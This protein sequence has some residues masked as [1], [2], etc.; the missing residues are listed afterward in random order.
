MKIIIHDREKYE[1]YQIEWAKY[2]ATKTRDD[3]RKYDDYVD[4]V[5]SQ[6][7]LPPEEWTFKSHPDYCRVTE[8]VT[9][10]QGCGF[11]DR[12]KLEY[13]HFFHENNKLLLELC[14]KND[15]VGKA[16]LQDFHAIGKISPTNLRYIYHAVKILEYLKQ[17]GKRKPQ[18]IEIGGGYG[19]LA[20]WL[21]ALSGPMYVNI[22][23]Y[24][25]F[26]LPP[27]AQLQKAFCLAM[28]IKIDTPSLETFRPPED[29]PYFLVSNF[30]FSELDVSLQERY[31]QIVFPY[32]EHGF[33]LWNI[34]PFET[35]K[36]SKLKTEQIIIEHEL[37]KNYNQLR[38]FF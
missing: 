12:L 23:S 28:G 21:H 34:T 5:Q 20:Y 2:Q 9:F 11:I 29:V 7:E 16:K 32:V 38:I 33:M 17:L 25:I 3:L 24:A 13:G 37:P 35:H 22:E 6:L 31:N 14:K 36:V 26:D 10:Q 8:N 18:I 1:A 15:A 4:V 27:V 30:A 19:G